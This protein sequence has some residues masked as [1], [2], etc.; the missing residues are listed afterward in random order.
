MKEKYSVLFFLV[1]FSLLGCSSDQKPKESRSII[2]FN[3]DWKF[4]LGDLKGVQKTTIIDNDWKPVRLPHDWSVEHPFTQENT[5]GA[6]AFLPGGIGWYRKIF[7]VSEN[8]KNKITTIEFDGIYS[9]AEVWI[10]GHYLGKHPYG[11]T[12]IT[13]DLTK[14]LKYNQ[15]NLIAVKVDRSA[16]IDS[17][18]YPGSGIYRNVL[19]IKQ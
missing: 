6:T 15:D 9:N 17:R 12:P 11:Y 2:D 1:I 19:K 13:Y 16:Y 8:A 10:N 3:F 5:A 14:Y 18:W 4:Y 7:R